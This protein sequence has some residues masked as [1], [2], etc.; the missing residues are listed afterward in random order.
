MQD[1]ISIFTY[2]VTPKVNVPRIIGLRRQIQ[3]IENFC[4]SSVFIIALQFKE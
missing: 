3:T 4:M 2:L 1:F